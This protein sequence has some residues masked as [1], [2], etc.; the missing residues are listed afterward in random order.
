MVLMFIWV[1][2][3]MC[4]KEDMEGANP[5]TCLLDA[6]LFFVKTRFK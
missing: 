5:R 4:F 3:S 1:T 2:G 6:C